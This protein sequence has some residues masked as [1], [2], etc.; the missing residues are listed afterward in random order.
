MTYTPYF[1]CEHCGREIEASVSQKTTYGGLT[2][3]ALGL[4]GCEESVKAQEREHRAR[5]ERRKRIRR[6]K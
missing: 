5:M 4:C 3:A 1:N 6:G 2:H